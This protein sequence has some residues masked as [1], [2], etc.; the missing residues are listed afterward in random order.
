M[1]LR[2]YEPDIGVRYYADTNQTL[3]YV[4]MRIRIRHWCT[5][6]CGYESDIDT[7]YYG[8]TSQ[9]MAYVTSGI[10]IK[11]W[12]CYYR[13]RNFTK[14]STSEDGNVQKRRRKAHSL[15]HAFVHG[16]TE[17]PFKYAQIRDIFHGVPHG[18]FP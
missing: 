16:G 8:D 4:T 7:I 9:E 10:R 1:L 13:G 2:G 15:H 14:F 6:L 11:H 5:L 12:L 18:V 3:V 17:Y